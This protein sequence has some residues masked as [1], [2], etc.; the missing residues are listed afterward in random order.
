MMRFTIGYLYPTVMSHYGDRGNIT[1]LLNRCRWRGIDAEVKGLELGERV[2]PEQVDI[3]FMGGGADSHQHLLC[4]DLL[5]VKGEGIRL[6]LEDG[7]PALVVCAGYQL[8]GNYYRPAQGEDLR[9]LEIFDAH[10]VHRATQVGARLDSFTGA[11]KV[12]AVGD[13]VVQW[14]AETLVGF[15]NHGGRTYLHPG[16]VPLGTVQV[17][18]GN[19]S[20]DG[21]E[22]CIHG[23]A[24]GTYLHGP[25]LPKNP[26]LADHLLELGLRR[27][28]GR[29]ELAPL[30]DAREHQAN[31]RAL[32]R[33]ISGRHS[34]RRRL[35]RTLPHRS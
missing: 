8:W 4:E 10:T 16:A 21:S 22:G 14:G 27:R 28:Y 15:E 17:G 18:G 25:V 29:A 2:D 35:S 30:P 34:G 31:R 26:A 3:L 7:C 9:G 33:A 32:E 11:R 19:N 20:E 12:R 1:S 24:I 6:A 23:S 5:G 13:L